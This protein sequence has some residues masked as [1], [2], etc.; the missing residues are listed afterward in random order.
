ML[1]AK[2]FDY[3]AHVATLQANFE[4]LYVRKA[5]HVYGW[6]IMPRALSVGLWRPVSL[7]WKPVERLDQVFLRTL[8]ASARRADLMLHLRA[9]L[10]DSPEDLYEVEVQGA[11]GDSRFS[12]RQRLLFEAGKVRFAVEAPRLWWPR[13]R[14]EQS[15][16]QVSV[17]LLKNGAEIDRAEFRHGIRTIAL[18]RTSVTDERGTG[19]FC[20][21]VNGEKIFILGTNH[22][23]RRRLSFA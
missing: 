8:S 9:R 12:Q 10:G 21:R 20:F 17:R 11:C 7:V 5:P 14:G 3:P 23:P 19:E 16:Y 2:K 22:V 15:L 4:S 13:G 18:D 6:D 1:E